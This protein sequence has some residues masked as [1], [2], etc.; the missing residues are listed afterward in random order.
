VR[1]TTLSPTLPRLLSTA[2][3]KE[4]WPTQ[5]SYNSRILDS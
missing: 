1:T 2:Q 5:L 3:P 4:T